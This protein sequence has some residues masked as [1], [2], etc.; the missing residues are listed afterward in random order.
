MR[1]VGALESASRTAPN[2]PA[3]MSWHSFDEYVSAWVWPRALPTGVRRLFSPEECKSYKAH[4]YLTTGASDSL[5]VMPVLAKFMADVVLQTALG[6]QCRAYIESFLLLVD[7]IE[8]LVG[9]TRGYPGSSAIMLQRV[10]H[11]HLAAHLA[12]Y[13]EEAWIPKHHMAIH[14]PYMFGAFSMLLGTMAMERRHRLIKRYG[15]D[16]R[17][18]VGW[19]RCLLE[20]LLLQHHYD[21]GSEFLRVGLQDPHPPS[22]NLQSV[23]NILIL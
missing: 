4:G 11:A 2:Q 23:H 9:A 16:R 3:G 7:A 22:R 14:L 8:A 15:T 10:I 1:L 13:G 17:T 18:M 5:A 19:E 12:A 20:E 6:K 21:L